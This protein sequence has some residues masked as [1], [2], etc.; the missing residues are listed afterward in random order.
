MSDLQK[1][2]YTDTL[3]RSRKTVLEAESGVV[4]P[5]EPTQN[6]GEAVKKKPRNTKEK[7]YLENSSN[8]LMDLRKASSHPMLFRRRYTDQTLAKVAKV[9]MK[10]PDFKKRG[11]V[12]ELVI[13]DMEVM[14][15]A[16]LQIFFAEYK[17]SIS[18]LNAR[19]RL[20]QPV[21]SGYSQVSRRRSLLSRL[22]EGHRF[23]EDARRIHQCRSQSLSILPGQFWFPADLKSLTEISTP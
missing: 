11:A 16:E 17:V 3:Q 23:I 13:E 9:L 20:R 4:T 1:T 19:V 18:Q 22:R 6:G 12:L 2:I 21:P 5:T 15:D 8:V 10:E 14:T 7:Q